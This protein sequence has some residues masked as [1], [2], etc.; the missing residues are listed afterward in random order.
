MNAPIAKLYGFLLVLFALLVLFTSNW[1][2]FTADELEA[3]AENKRPLLEQ[4]K[5]KRGEIRS[6]DGELLAVSKPRGKG[7]SK[8]FVRSYPSGSLFGHP[9]GYDYVDE[10]RTGIEKSE[11]DILV[12]AENEF[13]TIIEQLSGST[14]K[15]S[16]LTVTLDAGA[17]RV[18]TDLLS[19]QSAPGAVVALEPATGA[20]KVMASTPGYDPNL[21]PEQ[22]SE[23]NSPPEGAAPVLIN[24]ATQNPYPPGST[25]KVVTAAAALD[26]GEFTPDSTVDGDSPIEISGVPLENFGN[27]S[28]GTITLTDALTNSV[29]TAWAQVGE[30]LG[31]STMV[32]YMERFGFY[33]RPEIDYP[34]DQIRA[35]GPTRG[36]RL[37]KSG[38]DVGR[39]AIG[40][41]GAEG[42]MLATP[43]QMAMVAATIANGGKLI[44]PTFLQ[45]VTDPDGRVTDELEPDE[46]RQVVSPQTATQLT[47]MMV[48]VTREGTAAGLNVGTAPFAGKTG[49]AERNS[50]GLNQ[51]WFL[52][53]APAENPQIAV[54]ATIETCQGCFGG[55]VAGPIATA[56]AEDLL[57][58]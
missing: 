1:S 26:S 29:N 47:E 48:N 23:L 17:Q 57:G 37:V 2:V 54:V 34:E 15:G 31:T 55:E 50:E 25:M 11:N 27:K 33:S 42:Q 44:R 56:V 35:S 22:I 46:I 43:L 21:I 16:R 38:F 51:P 24:R 32:N 41:G 19:G 58:S 36:N 13:A 12:G 4:Q 7:E 8:R 45:Q 28:F 52:M 6:A 40:Q 30:Q 53:F 49:T 20:I 9:I 3:R 18:A 14:E 5:V 10:G 39:V